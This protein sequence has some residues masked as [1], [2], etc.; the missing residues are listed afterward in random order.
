MHDYE[1]CFVYMYIKVYLMWLYICTSTM[2]I[3]NIRT[4]RVSEDSVHILLVTNDYYFL[5]VIMLPIYCYLYV[6]YMYKFSIYI[7]ISMLTKLIH[8]IAYLHREKYIFVFFFQIN[9]K[10][11]SKRTVQ[12]NLINKCQ[13]LW[14]E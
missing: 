14:F 13:F 9:N 4:Q 12:T 3:Y 8:L 5:P 6:S 7:H 1:W 10:S 2:Y 11:E